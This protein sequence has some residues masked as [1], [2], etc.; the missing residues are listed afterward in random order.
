MSDL[1]VSYMGLELKNPVIAG[2]SGL[3]SS[4]EMIKRIEDAGAGAIVC[5]SLFE[6]EIQYEAMEQQIV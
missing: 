2:A 1:S 6:E 4:V 5:K 3:T